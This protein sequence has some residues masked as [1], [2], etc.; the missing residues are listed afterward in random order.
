MAERH[1]VI[2]P[3]L[4]AASRLG[5]RLF[6]NNAGVAFHKDGSAVRYGVGS[7]GGSDVLGW[8]PVR[9]DERHLGQVLAVFTAIE[10]K[11]GN[12]KP[13]KDQERFL[14]IVRGNG[15]LGYWGSDPEEIL[16][17]IERKLAK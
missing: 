7:P 13:S 15:G 16:A 14:Q 10:C 4:L 9:V 8:F 1:D 3:L 12:Q 5:G 11:T 2:D 6:R 17:K